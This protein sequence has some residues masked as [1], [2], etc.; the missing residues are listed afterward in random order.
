MWPI[1]SRHDLGNPLISVVLPCLDEVES[2]GACVTEALAALAGA[3]LVGEVVVVD[4]G[5]T[6]GSDEV[7]VAAGARLV[8]EPRAGYGSALAAGIEASRGQ[9]VVMADA[10]CSYDLSRIPD[11]ASWGRPPSPS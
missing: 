6:D 7:A 10:D 2:V 5:S 9:I 1:D 3:G 4:N 8:S 11:L